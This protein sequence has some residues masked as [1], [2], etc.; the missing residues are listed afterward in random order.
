MVGVWLTVLAAEPVCSIHH[1]LSDG[2]CVVAAEPVCSMI[3]DHSL[4]MVCVW[5]TLLAAEPV[6]SMMVYHYLPVTSGVGVIL[7]ACS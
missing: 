5:L 7:T 3:V 6:C 2:R 1:S 4:M